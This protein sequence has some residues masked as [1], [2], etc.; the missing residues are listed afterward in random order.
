MSILSR[1]PKVTNLPP[2]G[3]PSAQHQTHSTDNKNLEEKDETSGT[4]TEEGHAICVVQSR[5]K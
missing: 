2:R 4:A 3:L 5:E 1:E